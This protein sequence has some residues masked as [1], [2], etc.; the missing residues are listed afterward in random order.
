MNIIFL[1][2]SSSLELFYHI[3]QTLKENAEMN[4]IGFYLS[5]SSFFE[6]FKKV[7]PDLI[8]SSYH[9]LKEWEI[10]GKSITI[11]P[12]IKILKDY[13]MKYGDPVLWNAVLADRRIILGRRA[14]LRQN[15]K[16]RYDHDQTLSILQTGI[17]KME[18]FFDRVKPDIVVSFICVT[19]GEYLA[20]LIAKSKN[21]K[22]I[23]LR[24]T[25]IKNYIFGGESIFEPSQKLERVYKNILKNGIKDD[26]KNELNKYLEDV[27]KTHAMYEGVVPADN[28][29][30]N[31]KDKKKSLV[32]K[33]PTTLKKILINYYQY[34]FGEYKHDNSYNGTI[35]PYTFSKIL[36]PIRIFKNDLTLNNQYLKLKDLDHFEY[37][38][39][40]LHKEPEVTLLVYSRT[41]LNQ[42]E[43]I[44]NL[45]LNLPVG[46][47]LLVKEHPACIGYRSLKY[48][49]KILDIPNVV[50]VPP[51]IKSHDI[52]V[53]AKLIAIISG[54]I[55]LEALMHKKPVIHY[56]NVPFSFLPD[57]MIRCINDFSRTSQ[58]ITDIIVDH[59]HED[60][61][62]YAYLS[63]V[64]SLS[65]PVN[66]YSDLL[67]RQ[68]VYKAD[69][70]EKQPELRKK[71]L[72]RLTDYIYN[73]YRNRN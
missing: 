10:I 38:F 69:I 47:K 5:D 11:K 20:Y 64:Q 18:S 43:V 9:L 41:C 61:Y 30:K 65:I 53:K 68:G 8:N 13:E 36:K 67:G 15:Y 49:K 57:S 27:R 35:F 45:A 66:F 3:S 59:L 17:M 50:M 4:Q 52:I 26:L 73:I 7:N 46:M 44:R 37:I 58:T 23:N 56:G 6:K 12:D 22:F 31:S 1:T 40:P 33:I 2:Q 70:S 21:I 71:Q 39:Y 63:A 19:I 62:L 25:R 16:S 28:Q 60:K 34:N 32:K 72:Q 48:Y 29:M 55:G 51:Y 14:V 42:I 54:S 24:P